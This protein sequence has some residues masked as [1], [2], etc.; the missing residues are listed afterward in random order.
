MAK[1]TNA[2]AKSGSGAKPKAAR[3]RSTISSIEVVG[4]GRGTMQ[5]DYLL[6]KDRPMDK[7][8]WLIECFPEWGQFLNHQIEKA[9]VPRGNYAFWW[10]GGMGF[11]LKSPGGAVLLVDNYA[12]PGALHRVCLLRRVPHDRLADD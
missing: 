9:K 4:D 3:R 11:V 5:G 1:K 10:T 6:N 2:K 8:R 7:I 12:G